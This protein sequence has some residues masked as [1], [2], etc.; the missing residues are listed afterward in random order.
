MPLSLSQ[1][2]WRYF[3]PRTAIK[4]KKPRKITS[5]GVWGA[6]PCPPF[7]ECSGWLG[8]WQ[9]LE[10]AAVRS[11]RHVRVCVVRTL[12]WRQVRKKLEREI[13]KGQQ[14]WCCGRQKPSWKTVFDRYTLCDQCG[15]SFFSL[16]TFLKTGLTA[17][18]QPSH[19]AR[20][21]CC[22]V[23][24]GSIQHQPDCRYQT[25]MSPESGKSR[26]TPKHDELVVAVV[27]ET[28]VCELGSLL[29]W[30]KKAKVFFATRFL[31]SHRLTT[32]VPFRRK[33]AYFQLWSKTG[34]RCYILTFFLSFIWTSLFPSLRVIAPCCFNKKSFALDLC[35][36]TFMPSPDSF[37]LVHP[38]TSY[39]FPSSIPSTLCLSGTWCA[40][41]FACSSVC[42]NRFTVTFS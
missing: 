13:K 10:Q 20:Q 25:P 28:G 27:F 23:V 9:R 37:A 33:K 21:K 4:M 12:V 18:E 22:S 40:F 34:F 41:R 36:R 17:S 29:S 14:K 8:L 24:L 38:P 3:F 11:C 42:H 31:K 6:A 26:R 2:Q 30:Q 1:D 15:C 35:R 19:I 5:L 32:D 16:L 7:P 39:P